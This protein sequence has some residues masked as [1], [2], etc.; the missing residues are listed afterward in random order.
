MLGAVFTKERLPY[1]RAR[2]AAGAAIAVGRVGIGVGALVA[3]RPLLEAWIGKAVAEAPWAA[4][5]GRA[6]AGRDLALGV[7][8]LRARAAGRP[9]AAR[10][11]IALGAFAD[12][13]DMVAT[14][15]AWPDLPRGRRWLVLGLTLGATAAGALAVVD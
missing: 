11:A 9:K 2:H 3:P 15:K 4:V 14:L 13:V 5:L 8:A 6:L 10:A 7:L 1:R 12:G